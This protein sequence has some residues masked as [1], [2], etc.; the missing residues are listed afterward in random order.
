MERNVI[1][2]FWNCGDSSL[3]KLACERAGL[4]RKENEVLRLLLTECYTQEET[5]EK[6]DIST[7]KVQ[8]LW[9]SASSK[10]NLIYWVKV[11]AEATL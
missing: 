8:E 10:L 9:K 3:V 2:Q 7:R 1:K 5:A 6:M 4:T 11:V